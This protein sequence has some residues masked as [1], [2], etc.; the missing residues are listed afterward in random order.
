MNNLIELWKIAERDLFL[1][2]NYNSDIKLKCKTLKVDVLL[3]NF[4]SK[5]GMIVISDYKKIKSDINELSEMGFGYSVLSSSNVN[6]D[7]D[8]FIEMLS[9]WGW[10]GSEEDRPD[11]VFDSSTS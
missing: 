3:N 10:F 7:R 6:Y 2:V 4:G 8:S 1:N 11:W 5:K 9:D